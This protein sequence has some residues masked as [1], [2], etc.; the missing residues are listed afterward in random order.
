MHDK[1]HARLG[2][3]THR[4]P[5]GLD[6]LDVH[7]GG[8][9]R[10]GTVT[11]VAGATG[12]GK[13]QLGLRWAERGRELDGESGV[14]IDLTS[15]GDAQNH[16][17]YARSQFERSLL[18]FSLDRHLDPALLWDPAH[19]V[20]EIL[21]PFAQSGRRVTRP[22]LDPV[23][24][25]A[26]KVDMARVLRGSAGFLYAHL[27]RGCR[28]VVVDGL[29]PTDTASDSVQ[30]DYFEY[31]HH[32]VLKQD[33]EWAAREV[34]REA[35]R[36]NESQVH[37]HRYDHRAV[38]TLVLCTTPQVLLDDLVAEPVGRGGLLATASTVILMGRTKHAGRLGRALC[39]VKHR[40]SACRDEYL[41]YRITDAGI[42]FS[43]P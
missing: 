24:W 2:A 11:V 40:G 20:P 34:L 6:A 7:L 36:A 3:Q 18:E 15:R 22:D 17:A 19:R 21:R 42:D 10:P 32:H 35:Y 9:L 26:W 38:G 29:E 12:V 43:E 5:F 13:T 23:A 41:P 16:E 33:D 25:H 30:F 39:I 27:A 8:G 37:A 1:R 14:I 31:L 28:R 4:I